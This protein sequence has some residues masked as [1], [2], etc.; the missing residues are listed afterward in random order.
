ML[1]RANRGPRGRCTL[2]ILTALGS[3][4]IGLPYI[5]HAFGPTEAEVVAWGWVSV[6]LGGALT[7]GSLVLSLIHI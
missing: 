7:L 6:W 4:A 5:L 3:T 1:T 2:L